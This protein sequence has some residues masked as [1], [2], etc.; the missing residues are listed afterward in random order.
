MEHE[1]RI[2]RRTFVRRAALAVGL[3][4]VSVAGFAA[5]S[6]PVSAAGPLATPTNIVISGVTAHSFRINIGGSTVKKYDIF[7]NGLRL[8]T[9]AP[10]SS[11]VAFEVG[12]L[13][14]NTTYSVR[15]QENPGT[16]R[17]SALSRA[18]SVKTAVAPTIAP[19]TNL[20]LISAQG[21][22]AT[23]AWDATTTPGSIFYEI[24]LN[25][26]ANTSTNLTTHV[27]SEILGYPNPIAG[28]GVKPGVIN[29][30]GVYASNGF[31]DRSVVTEISFLAPPA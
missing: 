29:R 8:V 24:E 17:I 5:T 27:V 2:A 6:Q 13:T 21:T 31:G 1:H 16:G 22:S 15:V 14:P 10:A 28:T 30:I 7:G 11:S 25:G 4:A 18:V 26:V 12:Y 23:I 3:S 19:V 20:R 9:A